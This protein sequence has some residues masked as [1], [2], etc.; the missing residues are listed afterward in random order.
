MSSVKTPKT[1]SPEHNL[2]YQL[3]RERLANINNQIE[4]LR[5]LVDTLYGADL[6]ALE[7]QH[8]EITALIKEW[9]KDLEVDYG[10]DL[11]APTTS[12]NLKTGLITDNSPPQSCKTAAPSPNGA[13]KPR[14]SSVEDPSAPK[15]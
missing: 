10:L 9:A 6:R 8:R 7:H 4:S 15:E 1:L 11:T 3:H 2:Q 13:P 12:V 5:K 14:L